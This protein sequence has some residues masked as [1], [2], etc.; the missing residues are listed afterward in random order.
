MVDQLHNVSTRLEGLAEQHPPVPEALITIAGNVRGTATILE[1]L[2]A[3]KA[4]S[5]FEGRQQIRIIRNRSTLDRLVLQA[6]LRFIRR[7]IP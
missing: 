2:V 1:A 7:S 4:P 6:C 5:R 3:T